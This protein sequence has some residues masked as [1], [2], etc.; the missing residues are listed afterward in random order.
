MIM[1]NFAFN[2]AF[3]TLINTSMYDLADNINL[4]KLNDVVF[5]L[6]LESLVHALDIIMY[7]WS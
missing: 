7:K 1:S 6:K 4:S 5:T 3:Y 2:D